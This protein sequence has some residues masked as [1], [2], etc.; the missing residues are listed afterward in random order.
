M[1]ELTEKQKRLIAI[2]L[3]DQIEFSKDIPRNREALQPEAHN[4]ALELLAMPKQQ[5]VNDETLAE[6]AVRRAFK[7]CLERERIDSRR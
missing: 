5:Y 6:L 3:V 4:A 1:A 7:R 2:E